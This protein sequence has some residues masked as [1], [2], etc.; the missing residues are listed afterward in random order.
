[1]SGGF[2]L[3]VDFEEFAHDLKRDLGLWETGPLRVDA[4]WSGYE[5][6]ARFLARHGDAKATFFC[7][8]IIAERAPDLVGRIAADGHEVACHYFFHDEMDRSSAE[9]VSRFA[10]RAK[11]ALEDAAGTEVLGFRAPKFRIERRDPAQYRAIARLF[12]YDSSWY[13]ASPE[14][15]RAFLRRMGVDALALFPVFAAPPF[16]GAPPLRLG[17]SYLKLFPLGVAERWIA[18]AEAAGQAPIV[19]VHPYE[20]ATEG[21]FLL[22]LAEL[23]PLG[24]ARA[25]YWWLRQNQWHRAGNGGFEAKLSALARAQGL[26]G[27]LR[28]HLDAAV[29]LG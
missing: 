27:R 28:D 16:R 29:T 18:R 26:R 12:R 17:G 11:E 2:F 22:D 5:R 19:Y 13:G 25:A 1:V 10:A 15:A 20:L 21:D 7:T 9:D 14:E 23:A 3:T 24:A 6:I 8:G 4:L